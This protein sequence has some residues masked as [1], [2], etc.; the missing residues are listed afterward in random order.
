MVIVSSMLVTDVEHVAPPL[1]TCIDA[2]LC[3]V[4]LTGSNIL[5]SR[6]WL[7]AIWQQVL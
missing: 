6:W 5:C 2:L 7:A 1:P 4:L 3:N